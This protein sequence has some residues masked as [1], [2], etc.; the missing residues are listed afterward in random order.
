M[1]RANSIF[2]NF[3]QQNLPPGGVFLTFSAVS[4]LVFD[5]FTRDE[6]QT[7]LKIICFPNDD[8]LRHRLCR[9]LNFTPLR[10]PDVYVF[11]TLDLHLYKLIE[12]LR[13]SKK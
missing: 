11:A 13:K 10:I 7:D 12:A 9:S 3:E 4:L 8:L 1:S 5:R 2:S 6:G